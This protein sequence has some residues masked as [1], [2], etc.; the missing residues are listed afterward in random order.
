MRFHLEMYIASMSSD[1]CI[2][3]A[4][5]IVSVFSICWIITGIS[6]RQNDGETTVKVESAEIGINTDIWLKAVSDRKWKCQKQIEELKRQIA[7]Q[8][9][10]NWHQEQKLKVKQRATEALQREKRFQKKKV[11]ELIDER[12]SIAHR[13]RTIIESCM[14]Y[15]GECK[16]QIECEQEKNKRVPAMR[17]P[18]Y[19]HCHRRASRY[20]TSCVNQLCSCQSPDEIPKQQIVS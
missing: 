7:E 5:F 10:L 2:L 6:I 14:K 1:K 16:R 15:V 11:R 9:L 19:F 12:D 3:Y 8:E 13:N 17:S 4:M 20:C 18:R